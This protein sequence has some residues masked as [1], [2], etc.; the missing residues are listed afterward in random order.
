MPLICT[1][2]PVAGEEDEDDDEDEVDEVTLL[3]CMAG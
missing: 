3:A 1:I 2:M